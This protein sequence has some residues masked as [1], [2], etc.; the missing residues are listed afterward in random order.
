M[1]YIYDC[2]EY[3]EDFCGS[4]TDNFLEWLNNTYVDFFVSE[5][6]SEYFDYIETKTLEA[7]VD[8]KRGYKK[9]LIIIQEN[10]TKEY[11]G[12][13][14]TVYNHGEIYSGSWEKYNRIRTRPVVYKYKKAA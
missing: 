11:Y 2:D 8:Y 4:H 10:E 13:E 5:E 3:Q 14:Y 12:I 1:K 6:D 7:Y 9:Y